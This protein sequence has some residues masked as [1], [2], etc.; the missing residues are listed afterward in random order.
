MPILIAAVVL[1]GLFC[2]LDL[3]LTLGIIKR[4]REH[5]EL[6]SGRNGPKPSIGLGEEVGEFTASTIDGESLTRDDL[7]GETLVGI[8][9]PTCKPCREKL[10]KFVE[11]AQAIPGGR[12]RVVAAVVGDA[13][14]AAELVAQLRPVARVIQEDN[15]GTF[16]AAFQLRAFPTVLMI[17]PNSERRLVVKEDSVDLGQPVIPV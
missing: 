14:L 1:V 8:F 10:P 5:T 7:V 2:A 6:L 11:F 3:I 4:L 12:E 15:D 17:A 16:S 13:E 9:S